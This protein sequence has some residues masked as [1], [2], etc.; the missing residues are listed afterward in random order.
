MLLP[1]RDTRR[2]LRLHRGKPGRRALL[3]P[4]LLLVLASPT[5]A[6]RIVNDPPQP[7]WDQPD[8]ERFVP[9]ESGFTNR[10][11]DPDV[12]FGLRNNEGGPFAEN[13]P[14]QFEGVHPRQNC[15][16]MV[17][18][19]NS[20]YYCR[21]AE[22]GYCDR[23]SGTCWCE[24]GYAGEGCDQC[25]H[26]YYAEGDLCL[27]RVYC[28]NDC[29]GNGACNYTTG[30][31]DCRDHRLGADCSTPYC[32]KFDDNCVECEVNRCTRCI[33]GYFSKDSVCLSCQVCALSYV[34]D[35]DLCQSAVCGRTFHR[36]GSY[37]LPQPNVSAAAKCAL[38]NQLPP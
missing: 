26:A 4:A 17:G 20:Q 25:A 28:P 14:V 23:R 7:P 18:P 16:N 15:P 6:Y 29:S 30:E 1:R 27:P 19:I 8:H 5:A 21:G 33:D 10:I 22:F 36:D 37:C 35:G 34:N 32:K 13:V 3:A 24:T 9:Y 31:C 11:N 2:P 12:K 38:E